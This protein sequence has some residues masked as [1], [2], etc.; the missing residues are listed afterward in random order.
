MFER[1]LVPLDGSDLA[2]SVL[3]AAV[4]LAERFH[5]TL[6]LFHA[7]E[8]NAPTTVHGAHHLSDLT[9]ARAYLDALANRL[10]RPGLMIERHAHASREPDV[11]KSITRHANALNAQLIVLCAHGRS[12]LREALVGRIAQRVIHQGA[13]HVFLFRPGK[14]DD[15][16]CQKIL[17]PLDSAPVHEPALPIAAEFA[18]VCQASIEVITVV[19]TASTLSAERAAA[20]TFLPTT[21]NAVLDL[22]ERGAVDYLQKITGKLLA[23]GLSVK[24][25][26]AR[27]DAASEILAGA[28]RAGA[29]LIVLATHG[30]GT[31]EAFWAGSMT[32]QVIERAA[33]PLLL[34]H[35]TGEEAAR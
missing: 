14:I 7:L 31:I 34:V 20:S 19:P 15:W 13:T 6:I 1:L 21:T 5:A 26:V 25:Q 18:R 32:P 2:E 12:G 29:D 27:G 33:A 3:P 30:R 8:Q 24:G 35:V 11:A 17:V 16:H 9:E 4:Y 28:E 10:D 23:D 22:A